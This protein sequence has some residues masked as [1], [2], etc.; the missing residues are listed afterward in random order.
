MSDFWLLGYCQGYELTFIFNN[1][2]YVTFYMYK[3]WKAADRRCTLYSKL[4]KYKSIQVTGYYYTCHN[5]L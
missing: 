2:L 4:Y 5:A 1:V 3:D